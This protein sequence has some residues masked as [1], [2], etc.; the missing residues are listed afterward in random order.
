MQQQ[1]PACSYLYYGS[2]AQSFLSC[3]KQSSISVCAGSSGTD[4]ME[5]NDDLPAGPD[6]LQER[7]IQMQQQLSR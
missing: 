3:S 2:A 4:S 7:L 1:I 6:A 5:V